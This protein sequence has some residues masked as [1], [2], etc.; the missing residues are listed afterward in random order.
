MSILEVR[1]LRA[2]YG[3][4]EVVHGVN[5]DVRG[6][7]VACVVGRNGAGKTTSLLAIGGLL[8]FREAE[9]IALDGLALA[10]S[11]P[12]EIAAAG[13][14]IVPEGHRVFPSLSV[15]DNLRLGAYVCRKRAG[16]SVADAHDRVFALFPALA[17]FRQ[18]PAGE[19]SG[20]QQQMLAIGQSL[21]A[22]PSMLLLDEPSSGLAPGIVE[23]IYVSLRMLR[24]DGLGVLVVEQ[25]IDLGLAECEYCYVVEQG[26]VVLEGRSGDVDAEQVRKIV[27]GEQLLAPRADQEPIE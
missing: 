17:A 10:R 7:S 20:G 26:R 6:G 24:D 1:S 5:L 8:R 25:N 22:Q 11:N 21:M 2:G 15:L 19:L 16:Y 18:R 12:V 4:M 23:A 3:G 14:A 13:I 27:L 9:S